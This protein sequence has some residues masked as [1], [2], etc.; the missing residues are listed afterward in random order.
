MSTTQILFNSP[1][2]HSLKRDQLVKLCKIHSIKA[3]GKN[4]DL[5][6]KLKQHALS[7][8]QAEQEANVTGEAND[9]MDGIEVAAEARLDLSQEAEHTDSSNAPDRRQMPRPS[10]Q[11][12]VVM[13][14]I[15]EEEE[16]SS[17]N[18]VSSK[19]T[20]RTIG[21]S[22]NTTLAGEFGTGGSKTSLMSSSLKAFAT[23][24]G[25]NRTKGGS[26]HS[27]ANMSTSMSDTSFASIPSSVPSLP[28]TMKKLDD[29]GELIATSAPYSS[30]PQSNN[31]P[32]TDHLTFVPPSPLPGA[33]VD[34]SDPMVT[35]EDATPLPGHPLRPGRP[36]PSAPNV[37]MSL[38]LNTPARGA[39]PTTTIRLVSGSVPNV[40]SLFND[41]DSGDKT[42]TSWGDT[43]WA[44]GDTPKLKPFATSFDLVLGSP[45]PLYPPLPLDE[46]VNTQAGRQASSSK[47][48]S[49]DAVLGTPSKKA[50]NNTK[51][52]LSPPPKAPFVFG[53]PL[54]QHRISNA[55]F[56][57]AAKSVLDEMNQRLAGEGVQ[58]VST[59]VLKQLDP[60][61]R[62][63]L[64]DALKT[65]SLDTSPSRDRQAERAAVREKFNRAHEDAFSKMAGIDEPVG[66]GRKRKS[67][68]L[69]EKRESAGVRK[70][71]SVGVAVRQGGIG[72]N[73]ASGA[74]VISG[75]RRKAA[76]VIPG[77]F[78]ESD[79]ASQDEDEE[80]EE[81]ERG[82]KRIKVQ[83]EEA[84]AQEAEA[85]AARK[86]KERELV[87]RKLEKSKAARRSSMGVARQSMGRGRASLSR[88]AVPK[89]KPSR[90]GFLS[91]AKS[92]VQGMW[93]GKS[94]AKA[95]AAPSN[96]SIPV[97]AKSAPLTS[98][99]KAS[100][101]KKPSI[102]PGAVA[103]PGSSVAGGS[104]KRVASGGSNS[105]NFLYPGGAEKSNTVKS[106]SSSRSRSP[107]PS[108]N[109]PSGSKASLGRTST[110]GAVSSIGTRSGTRQNPTGTRS[111]TTGTASNSVGTRTTSGISSL[112]TRTSRL[113]ST[114]VSTDAG[115][116]NAKS[117]PSTSRLSS[118]SRLMAPTA[119]SL[120]KTHS[121][122]STTGLDVVKE[123]D[124]SRSPQG[125]ATTPSSKPG[126]FNKHLMS[127]PSGIPTPVRTTGAFTSF[128]G[129]AASIASSPAKEDHS[130]FAPKPIAPKPR[131]LIGRKPRISRS[132]VIA[133]LAS[134]RD[135]PGPS[136]KVI[137]TS[138]DP[139]GGAGRTRSSLGAKVQRE[140]LGG[141]L[142]SGKA[143][144]VLMAR[145]RA[146]ASEYARRKSLKGYSGDSDMKVDD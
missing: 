63:N 48:Q 96:T 16:D 47:P 69:L 85:E 7:L 60:S 92:L 6:E 75:G 64:S 26:A 42:T 114:T 107:I 141:G 104:T 146:R 102:G 110:S 30:L 52:A 138:L 103:P 13:D 53:S 4:T 38:G 5:V 80:A 115:S 57:D 135:G 23:S 98:T 131:S 32:Q 37:R 105:S 129:A 45:G 28:N 117:M 2:L 51:S 122:G 76:R 67:N 9:D 100:T 134:K 68:V 24:L 88:N 8:Q 89:P 140:G 33:F 72:V 133:K 108:F 40:A 3:S 12:E 49:I 123:K 61:R 84:A 121:R 14:S 41:P 83:D 59:D 79:S 36:A 10:E 128:G 132:K 50:Q 15:D 119:S 124:N 25:L 44:G 65:S 106:N 126:I 1:A 78:D 77:G 54:P 127:S 46:L 113:S 94:S 97:P 112:G 43:T 27:V 139:R 142:K 34:D 120:A 73:R 91:S 62:V 39:G 93:K 31:P 70:R 95:P 29:Q 87:K 109:T 130:D 143:E 145:K 20:L 18:T 56:Q 101:S 144:A 17:Q 99:T 111:S 19:G 81:A 35:T 71:S 11:W 58:S 21:G 55:Q 116:K 66:A 136:G 82:G 74:R 118:S 90:F 137:R 22:G 125:I 86:E